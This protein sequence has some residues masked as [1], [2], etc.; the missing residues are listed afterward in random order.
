MTF[1]T[2]LADLIILLEPALKAIVDA[3][4]KVVEAISYMYSILA[5][6]DKYIKANSDYWKEYTESANKA[7]KANK[8]LISGFDDLNRL[9]SNN[10]TTAS[11]ISPTTEADIN[12]D[13]SAYKILDN[14]K[15]FFDDMP[16]PHDW[17]IYIDWDDFIDKGKRAFQAV[18]EFATEFVK[19]FVEGWNEGLRKIGNFEF[20][21][22]LE[23]TLESLKE[24][25]KKLKELGQLVVQPV[26]DVVI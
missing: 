3:L 12:K 9:N 22:V 8:L 20:I 10:A 4:T 17:V 2:M 23:P 16:Y 14:I 6:K 24:L 25:A 13:S 15:K 21:P 18:T 19:G 1:G 11:N 5:G 26:V 7:A